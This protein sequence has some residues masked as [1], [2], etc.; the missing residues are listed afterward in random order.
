VSSSLEESLVLQ[1]TLVQIVGHASPRPGV[2]GA[3]PRSAASLSA[4]R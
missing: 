4:R 1:Q 3:R 2:A